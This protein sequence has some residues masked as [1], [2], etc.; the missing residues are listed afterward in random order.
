MISSS[1]AMNHLRLLGMGRS[2]VVILLSCDIEPRPSNAPPSP[3][4][5]AA[6]QR[7][8]PSRRDCTLIAR[9]APRR[10]R[11]NPQLG[12][13]YLVWAGLHNN[14]P[15]ALQQPGHEPKDGV[16]QPAHGPGQGR[17]GGLLALPAPRGRSKHLRAVALTCSK[18]ASGRR[19]ATAS[20]LCG[21]L[22]LFM[23][24]FAVIP[25]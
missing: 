6:T 9:A 18:A 2:A 20:H 11:S 3:S 10:R 8:T 17:R 25:Q 14:S 19:A 7:F 12:S 1:T 4:V 15:P 16:A 21:R 13:G 24:V 23:L 22:L 5:A